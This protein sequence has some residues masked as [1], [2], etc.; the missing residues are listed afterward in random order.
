MLIVVAVALILWQ[1]QQIKSLSAQNAALHEEAREGAILREKDEQSLA[2]LKSEAERWENERRELLRLRAQESKL[3]QTEQENTR[4]KAERDRLAREP[5][6]GTAGEGKEPEKTPEQKLLAAKSIFGRNLG[7]AFL[8][9]AEENDGRLPTQLPNSLAQMLEILSPDSDGVHMNS[10]QFELVY[11]GSLRDLK[12][13]LGTI[14]AR[15]REPLQ[16]SDGRWMR[17]YVLADGSSQR[18]AAD[19]RDGFAAREQEFFGKPNP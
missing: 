18:V 1:Q 12:N 9:A 3:R 14:L 13:P 8:L 16:L 11:Q 5:V 15:E 4:L 10:K 7:L 17:I 6:P 19:T 2:G